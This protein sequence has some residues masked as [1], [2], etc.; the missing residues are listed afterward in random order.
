[1]PVSAQT[2]ELIKN[3]LQLL[4]QEWTDEFDSTLKSHQCYH[5][6]LD[7]PHFLFNL[8]CPESLKI[9]LSYILAKYLEE[10]ENNLRKDY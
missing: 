1:M 8:N 7:P 6:E 5:L 3:E 10:K 9:K 2:T 4:D